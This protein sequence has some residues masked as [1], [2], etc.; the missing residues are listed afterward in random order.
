MKR[1]ITFLFKEY[2]CREI[3]F[4]ALAARI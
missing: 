2:R 1:T 3:A 4:A